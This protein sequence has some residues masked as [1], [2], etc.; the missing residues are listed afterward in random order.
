MNS[1]VWCA[2]LNLPTCSGYYDD[3]PCRA[4]SC[5]PTHTY[6]DTHRQ[7]KEKDNQE[8]EDVEVLESLHKPA[9]AVGLSAAFI[10][11]S[12]WFYEWFD[13]AYWR[14]HTWRLERR[15]DTTRR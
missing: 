15:R 8:E 9:L 2:A 1:E 7:L 4:K 10:V 6:C 5:N 12:S 14:F 3:H 11:M 13:A